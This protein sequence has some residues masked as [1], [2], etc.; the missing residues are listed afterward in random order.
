MVDNNNNLIIVTNPI[1]KKRCFNVSMGVFAR[2]KQEAAGEAAG[3][4]DS[5]D[6]LS[7]D[8]TSERV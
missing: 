2:V 5:P 1:G 8:E 4:P 6:S 7:M 3:V